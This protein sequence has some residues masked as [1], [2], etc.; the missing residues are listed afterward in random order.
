MLVAPLYRNP[1]AQNS[2]LL[3]V[4]DVCTP[5]LAIIVTNLHKNLLNSLQ[6]LIALRVINK[7]FPAQL[8]EEACSVM[9]DNFYLLKANIIA[10]YQE[11]LSDDLN[12]DP[13]EIPCKTMHIYLQLS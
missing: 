3:Y 13:M 10:R 4:Q 11:K 6:D 8:S 2:T 5:N 9:Q 12:H 7:N 1:A